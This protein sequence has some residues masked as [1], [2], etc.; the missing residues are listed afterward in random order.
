MPVHG[1]TRGQRGSA[2]TLSAAVVQVGGLMDGPPLTVDEIRDKMAH[3]QLI[4]A[5]RLSSNL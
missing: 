1:Y 5:S 3:I 2:W 4:I